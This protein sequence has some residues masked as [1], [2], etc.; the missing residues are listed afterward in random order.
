[1]TAWLRHQGDAVNPKRVGRLPDT[2]F[3]RICCGG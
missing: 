3:T 1:M 2:R